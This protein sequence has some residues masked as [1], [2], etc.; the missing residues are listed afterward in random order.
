MKPHVAIIAGLALAVSSC[1]IG[2]NLQKAPPANAA[3][4]A[5]KAVV[6]IGLPP[7]PYPPNGAP[8]EATTELGRRLFY[9]RNLSLDGSVACASC[10]N[11]RYGFTDNRAVGEGVGGRKGTRNSPTLFNVA[12]GKTFSWDGRAPTLE[13]QAVNH[14]GNIAEMAHTP[15]ALEAKLRDNSIYRAM[16]ERA[17]GPGPITI[18]KAVKALGVF[19]RLILSGNSLYDRYTYLGNPKAL[20]Q[21]AVRGLDI[22]AKRGNCAVCHQLGKE[23]S[24]FTDGLYH[25]LGVGL[26]ARGELADLGRYNVTK[27]EA[28]K[29]AFKTP[30]L[31]NITQSRPYMHDG[32]LTSLTEVVEFYNQGG[33]PNPHLSKLI[34]P[35]NLTAQ[36]KIDLITFLESLSGE[37]VPNIGPPEGEQ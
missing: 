22:F 11:P 3:D 23:Y 14:L 6:P 28:D 27:A 31:R 35:L 4:R 32:S 30:T 36:D 20:S 19:Q 5:I 13:Q 8:T 34:R 15:A 7:V 37:P 16:F 12:Y 2:S 26:G 29:G 21:T 25:N 9:D 24:L 10:H 33:R 17:Y 1:D 18:E